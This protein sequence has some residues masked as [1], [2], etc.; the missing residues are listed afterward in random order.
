LSDAAKVDG[1]SEIRI[2]WQIIM[3]LAR[4]ALIAVSNFAFIGA[5]ED[6]FNPL[7]YLNTRRKFTLQL[8][9]DVFSNNYGGFPQYNL[10]MA[11]GIIIMLPVIVFYFVGQRYFIE[12]VTLTGQKG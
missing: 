7:I 2:W 12:G 4:P 5:W 6:F 8:G 1:A 11:V 9:L 10:L 3:P